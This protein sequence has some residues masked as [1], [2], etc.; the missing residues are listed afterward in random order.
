MYLLTN[1]GGHRSYGNGN[2]NSYINFYTNTL[3]KAEPTASIRQT[4][5][6]F[7]SGIPIYNPEVPDMAYGK[8]TTTT[9]TQVIQSAMRF[10]QTQ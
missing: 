10:M 2:I 4:E 8:T 1:F 7:K 3:D 9:R 5:R 6:F